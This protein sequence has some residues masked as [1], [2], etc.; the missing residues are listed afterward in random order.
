MPYG[1]LTMTVD[2]KTSTKGV[3]CVAD[4]R[5]ESFQQ[6]SG[7]RISDHAQLGTY[8]VP[9]H[10]N[11]R[12]IIEIMVMFGSEQQLSFPTSP[13]P[14]LSDALA[15]SLDGQA[16]IDAKFYL[17]STRSM[18]KPASPRAT[19]G[20]SVILKKMATYFKDCRSSSH[21]SKTLH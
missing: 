20:N 8:D 11:G 5:R 17:F 4:A 19:F 16:L 18:G 13:S 14:G 2:V 3:D 15:S 21:S 9:F 10:L 6:F 7:L 1:N 12:I